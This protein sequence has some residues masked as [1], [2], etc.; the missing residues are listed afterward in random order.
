MLCDFDGADRGCEAF[1]ES[2]DD[3]NEGFDILMSGIRDNLGL[4]A[5]HNRQKNTQQ[6]WEQNT[7]CDGSTDPQVVEQFLEVECFCE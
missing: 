1:L 6:G 7:D 3:S 2:R 4:Y 5:I